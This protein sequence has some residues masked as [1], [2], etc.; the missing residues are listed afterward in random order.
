MKTLL[1]FLFLLSLAILPSMAQEPLNNEAIVKLVQGGLS[2]E[3]IKLTIERQ[4]GKYS[5]S[6]D[7]LIALSQA[8]VSS[9][10]L[11]AMQNAQAAS[12]VAEP[13]STDQDS[14]SLTFRI[15]ADM[16]QITVL[17]RSTNLV[18]HTIV[19]NRPANRVLQER[20][21]RFLCAISSEKKHEDLDIVDLRE[22][23]I[24]R[25]LPLGES[26][27]RIEMDGRQTHLLIYDKGQVDVR[28]GKVA[29]E[30]RVT[31]LD[32]LSQ[33]ATTRNLSG[34]AASFTYFKEVDRV[35]VVSEKT[36]FKGE[37]AGIKAGLTFGIAGGF[38]PEKAVGQIL[39]VVDIQDPRK[40]YTLE[41]NAQILGTF[42]ADRGKRLVVLT[43]DMDKKGKHVTNQGRLLVYDDTG[44]L[45]S[46]SEPL[47]DTIGLQYAAPGSG[48][49]LILPGYLRFVNP[50]GELT[51]QRL[52]GQYWA[53][54]HLVESDVLLTMVRESDENGKH[55][56]KQGRVVATN[57][58]GEVLY[59][60]NQ[61]VEPLRFMP[62]TGAAGVWAISSN[63]MSYISA[64]GKPGNQVLSLEGRGQPW[65]A[66]QIDDHRFAAV[67]TDGVGQPKHEVAIFNSDTNK[68]ETVSE[69]GDPGV[70]AGRTAGRWAKAIGI[71]AAFAMAGAAA[72]AA[73][74]TPFYTTYYITPVYLPGRE[75]SNYSLS[76]SRDKGTLYSL[77]AASDRI[78]AV[79]AADGS[80]L[81]NITV[82]KNAGRLWRSPDGDFLYCIGR[83][84]LNVIDTKAN[85]PL[86]EVE[87]SGGF[88]RTDL[89]SQSLFLFGTS[90]LESWDAV[91]AQKRTV[92]DAGVLRGFSSQAEFEEVENEGESAETPG[93]GR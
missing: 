85:Q 11:A 10:I 46:S 31:I 37:K 78:T 55:I 16:R 91:K 61:L 1:R 32:I 20:S 92:I 68:L 67:L 19:L 65:D 53:G 79:K 62:V 69:V 81:G 74:S 34:I 22:G 76:I 70:R 36:M 9:K 24:A 8:G 48:A 28:S 14:T 33:E 52:N 43:R 2:D 73:M 75:A 21:G 15:T 26:V 3:V 23:V 41:P 6:A 84:H 90:G 12:S 18:L 45:L 7:D 38:N 39:L 63:S 17:N 83:S 77:D 60:S 57:S 49:W 80:V 86:Q 64:A 58:A 56:S 87:L 35:Q 50:K 13:P 40:Y 44:A 89:V 54:T 47:S 93:S 5:L 30:A 42:F 59:T 66:L 25:S 29:R 72:G 4:P 27:D 88:V 82:H 51:N 71:T